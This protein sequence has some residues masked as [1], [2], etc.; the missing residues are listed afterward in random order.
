MPT[1]Y[2]DVDRL[3]LERWDDTKGLLEAF[4]ELQDRMLDVIDDGGERLKRWAEQHDCIID[5]QAKEPSYHFYKEAWKNRR[6]DDALVYFTLADFAPVGYRKVK[7]DHPYVWL[8]TDN[9]QMMRMKEPDRVE[10][11]RQLRANLGDS[12]ARWSHPETIDADSPLGR[13]MT[14]VSDAD[15]VRLVAEPDELLK[16]AT[17]AIEDALLLSDAVNLTLEHFKARE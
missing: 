11:A 13:Y 5:V 4:E 10:F 9:L 6:K 17:T 7:N 16:F 1:T 14:D 3:I 12:A 2:T 8:Y 15:R